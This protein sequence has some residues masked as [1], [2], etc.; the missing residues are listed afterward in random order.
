MM[1]RY[2][3]DSD[4]GFL[5]KVR[6]VLLVLISVNI[7]KVTAQS[8]SNEPTVPSFEQ[9]VSI[10]KSPEA[11]AFQR[12]G[13]GSVS[14]FNGT[15]D[16][17]I[18]IGELTG[19]DISL[20]VTLT[21][22][23]SGIKV[24]QV[25]SEVGLGWNLK[26]GGMIVRQVNGL[27][28]DYLSATPLYYPYYSTSNY[29]G[30][31]SVFSQYEHFINNNLSYRS[32]VP[33]VTTGTSNWEQEWPVRYLRYVE[34]V[35]KGNIDSQPDTYS[36]SIN[37]LSGTLVIDYNTST[38]YCI[39]NPEIKV[40]PVL[41]TYSN[42]VKRIASWQI[43]DGDGNVY[44]FGGGNAMET[45]QYYENNYA[46]VNRTY[47]SAWKISSI[48]TGRLKEGV[49][50]NYTQESWSNDQPIVSY[51]SIDA[52]VIANCSSL[53][54]TPNLNPF[55]KITSGVLSS[56]KFNAETTNRLVVSR[57]SRTDLPGQTAIS[58]LR[59]ND[60]YGVAK[61][62][63]K[64]SRGYFSTGTS[65]LQKRLKLN[66][67]SFHGDNAGSTNPQTYSFTYNSTALPS[68]DSKARDYYGYY[69][70]ANSNS[71]LL[72]Y[73][74]SLGNG[75][76]REVNSLYTQAGMLTQ[77]TYPT[78]G[79]TKFY[80]QPNIDYSFSTNA[81]WQTAWSYSWTSG[82]PEAYCDDIVGTTLNVQYQTFTA[83]VTGSYKINFTKNVD[84]NSEVQ[85]IALYKGTKTLCDLVWDNGSDILYKQYSQANNQE[86]YV[87]LEANV[88]YNV[89]MA[90]NTNQ[91]A[92]MFMSVSY[93]DNVSL[94]EYKSSAGVR[95]KKKEDYSSTGVVANTKYYYYNDA[96]GLDGS[97]IISL[98]N[99][100]QYISSGINQSKGVF[101][102]TQNR[103][104]FDPIT[105]G[106][107]T[108]QYIERSGSSFTNGNGRNFTYETVSELTSDGSGEYHL[109]VFGFQNFSEF[110]D[111]PFISSSPLLGR[112]T[113][114]RAYT[115]ESTTGSFNLAAET[116]NTYEIKYISPSPSTIK[117]LYY[118]NT[119]MYYQNYVLRLN[120]LT[121]E[122]AWDYDVMLIGE[123]GGGENGSGSIPQGCGFAPAYFTYC[124]QNGPLPN[125]YQIRLGGYRKQFLQLKST[126]VKQY[127]RI[128]SLSSTKTFTYNEDSN[129]QIAQI[130]QTNSNG[131]Q[132]KDVFTFP[133]SS[134]NAALFNQNRLKELVKSQHYV[135]N[136]LKVEKNVFYSTYSGNRVLLQRVDE[137]MNG[138]ASSNL[139]TVNS[140]D[141]LGN[142]REI[143]KRD[144]IPI[145]MVWGHVGTK[146]VLQA[147]GATYTQLLSGLGGS[148]TLSDGGK[149]FTQSQVASLRGNL[150]QAMVNHFIFGSQHGLTRT[151][152]Q[153]GLNTDYSYD[154]FGRLKE[155]RDH[156]NNVLE[157]YSFNIKN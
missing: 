39:D 96:S 50:F 8:G 33:R 141:N 70:G 100:G 85:L 126:T 79:F 28:D 124:I 140:Y 110:V 48:T 111:G 91:N 86:T 87:T 20:P 80:Y 148:I 107:Y 30:S 89:A 98:S 18:P 74:S 120:E 14:Y 151:S 77:V 114:E 155:V 139:L 143:V 41:N 104:N 133:T 81:V 56:I 9:L 35:M 10:P 105:E 21:Y 29:P 43:I 5:R 45:T 12:Y 154:G 127:N 121:G 108:C 93:L 32:Y 16:V 157:S 146:V 75:G 36:L 58:Q 136:S 90:N 3:V 59:I 134:N 19:R 51:Y 125:K 69:N 129:Y 66:S 119:D 152:D 37:G 57:A 71:T 82:N 113:V 34:E 153:N 54:T 22:D 112:P 31:I 145:T 64:F 61:S 26:V 62:Y 103:E 137:K 13:N 117:A 76:V 95:L 63:V 128:A 67:V 138:G 46:E 42:G 52:P 150:S 135:N 17:A 60:E 65:H 23:A 7:L 78:K 44:I 68:R 55:Y 118:F 115:Y 144:G 38:G 99:S 83:P 132:I 101:E 92:T 40:Y 27:P 11:F 147:T 15:P 53:S 131:E 1:V 106:Y 73:N 49:T 25:A 47:T 102:K 116:S 109:K 84:E 72:P 149:N 156:D 142:I 97:S 6:N 94:P 2:L 123:L 24:D 130:D 88:Q 4:L 122:V